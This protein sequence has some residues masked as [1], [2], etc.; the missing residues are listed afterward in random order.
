MKRPFLIAATLLIATACSEP[1]QET[2]EINNTNE[3]TKVENTFSHW[4]NKIEDLFSKKSIGVLNHVTTEMPKLYTNS[5]S[6]GLAE[7][8]RH[9]LR[10]ANGEFSK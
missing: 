5:T 7:L 10:W 9:W 1:L 8:E 2:I 4:G 3:P 6:D